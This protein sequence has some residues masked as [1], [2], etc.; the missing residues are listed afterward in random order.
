MTA[1][2][3]N[4]KNSGIN[5]KGLFLSLKKYQDKQAFLTAYDLYFD[6]IF[7][8]IF[9]KIG[10]RE[11][12]QD[13]ASATFLKC[14]GYV[15]D[16]K[17]KNDSEYKSL[18]SFLY[19]IARNLAIDYYRQAKPMASLEEA[20]D[21]V[22]DFDSQ[23]IETDSSLDLEFVAGKLKEL[24]SEYRNVL[25]LKYV[26]DLSVSEIASILGKNKGNIRVTIYRALEALKNLTKDYE[27]KGSV[28]ST[29]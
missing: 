1:K 9:F 5:E 19:K 25:I 18:K 20:E 15:K 3:T 21:I 29:K 28:D 7:R 27:G 2:P 6:Q 23:I 10:N 26:N 12:A 16:G 13:L 8:F 4:N 22:S 17:L 14:W 11:D 24:K